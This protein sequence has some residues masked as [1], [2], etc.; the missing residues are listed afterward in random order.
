MSKK[1]KKMPIHVKAGKPKYPTV[2]GRQKGRINKRLLGDMAR[3]Q[4][5]R[6]R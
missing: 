4:T 5:K 1:S 2:R 6:G 3:S